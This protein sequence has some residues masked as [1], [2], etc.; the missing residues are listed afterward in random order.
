MEGIKSRC[1]G[2]MFTPFC[3][4]A[5][6]FKHVINLLNSILSDVLCSIY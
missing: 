4:I 5:A 3:S 2:V 6:R 1:A